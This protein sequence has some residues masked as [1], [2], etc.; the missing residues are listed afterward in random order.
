MKSKTDIEYLDNKCTFENFIIDNS[1]KSAFGISKEI[2]ENFDNKNSLLF[3]YG[4][5]GLGK[6]HLLHSIE[7]YIK[8]NKSN[9]GI[10]YVRFSEF[11][12]DFTTAYTTKNNKLNDKLVKVFKDKYYD[13]DI[14]IIDDIQFLDGAKLVQ[15]ELLNIIRKIKQVILTSNSSVDEL[16]VSD[17]LKEELYNSIQ[18]EIGTPSLPFKEKFIIKELEKCD[19]KDMVNNEVI[20]YIVDNCNDDMRLIQGSVMRLSTYIN[21]SNTIIDLD[22]A[23]EILEKFLEN[24]SN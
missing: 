13:K 18:V 9:T 7:N 2:A 24:K 8:E 14:L 21:K 6:T 22:I 12:D 17:N 11:V 3:I 16:D 4:K 19:I 5:N 15:H 10:L 20:N 23:K 1:N